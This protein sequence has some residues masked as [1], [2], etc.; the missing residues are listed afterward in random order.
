MKFER[1]D[2]ERGVGPSGMSPS[3][4]VSTRTIVSLLP[5]SSHLASNLLSTQLAASLLAEPGEP[6]VLVRLTLG[7]DSA[8]CRIRDMGQATVV[9][10]APPEIILQSQSAMLPAF[11]KAP[12]G[13]YMVNLNFGSEPM[14]SRRIELLL[15]HLNRSFAHI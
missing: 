6:V 3:A 12:E 7:P 15:E 8:G 10:W 5:L 1:A 14:T 9:D 2:G 13:F 4:A 11:L